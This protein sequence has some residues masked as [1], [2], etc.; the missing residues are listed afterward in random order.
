MYARF[1]DAVHAAETLLRQAE[2]DTGERLNIK[3]TLKRLGSSGS[4]A[5]FS[6]Q[7]GTSFGGF[8]HIS[9]IGLAPNKRKRKA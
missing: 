8:V 9:R 7:N 3:Q 6:S 1:E 4:S 2:R 5:E